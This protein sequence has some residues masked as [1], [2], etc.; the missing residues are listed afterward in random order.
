MS[1]SL[2]EAVGRLHRDAT[3]VTNQI[4]STFGKV[5]PTESNVHLML[6]LQAELSIISALVYKGITALTMERVNIE[7]EIEKK[8]K[9]RGRKKK[10]K[11]SS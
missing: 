8:K 5:A 11:P 9:C 4:Q 3:R 1:E 6:E 10:Q 7:G 2:R